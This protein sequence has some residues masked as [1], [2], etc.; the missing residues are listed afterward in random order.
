MVN[1]GFGAGRHPRTAAY[2]RAA[3]LTVRGI[4]KV[5]EGRPHCVDAM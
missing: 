1:L 3:A 4:N 5:F 2:L